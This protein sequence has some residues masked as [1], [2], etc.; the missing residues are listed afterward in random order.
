M[1]QKKLANCVKAF[2]LLSDGCWNKTFI[3]PPH[4]TPWDYK[5][6]SRAKKLKIDPA[7]A[8]SCYLELSWRSA[9]LL[10]QVKL[11]LTLWCIHP[12]KSGVQFIGICEE[13]QLTSQ[14]SVGGSENGDVIRVISRLWHVKYSKE[15]S[16]SRAYSSHPD[17]IMQKCYPFI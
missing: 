9:V 2:I 8:E 6:S 17:H 1:R 10:I 16:F 7:K 4:S 14:S 5:L 3:I 13:K 12:N 11:W 15:I